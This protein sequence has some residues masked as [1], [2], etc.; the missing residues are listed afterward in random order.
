MV[1]PTSATDVSQPVNDLASR[2]KIFSP[3]E[4]GND[5]TERQ[6][7]PMTKQGTF[8][9]D[10][11]THT[12]DGQ[13]LPVSEGQA[14]VELSPTEKQGTNLGSTHTLL[15]KVRTYTAVFLKLKFRSL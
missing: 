9:K 3:T 2:R 7:P 4:D 6:R 1:G 14:L 8:T 12:L 5:G 10:S 15:D 11:P 13:T